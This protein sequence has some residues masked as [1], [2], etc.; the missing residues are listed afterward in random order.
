M[1]F[2]E[3]EQYSSFYGVLPDSSDGAIVNTNLH[4]MMKSMNGMN[5]VP[6]LFFLSN[7]VQTVEKLDLWG[8]SNGRRLY[9]D[10]IDE[11]IKIVGT[12]ALKDHVVGVPSTVSGG[13]TT[14]KFERRDYTDIVPG[15]SMVL[16]Q[17]EISV[18]ACMQPLQEVQII[19]RITS[20]ETN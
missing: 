6:S 12:L 10:E 5:R 13:N 2:D 15:F 17:N 14:H 1:T 20:S 11:T 19:A 3:L 8:S 4:S 16:N 18:P 7:V 9:G